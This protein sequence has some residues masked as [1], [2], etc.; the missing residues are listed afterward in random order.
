MAPVLPSLPS[1][2]TFEVVAR[3]MSFTRAAD[4][5]NIT[6]SAVSRQIRWLEDL[7]DTALFH[8]MGHRVNLTSDGKAYLREISGA[9]RRIEQS[10]LKLRS[11]QHGSTLTLA[12]PPAFGMRWLI[13]RLPKFHKANPDIMVSLITRADVFDF[14]EESVDAALHYGHEDWAGVET[15]PLLG[16]KIILVASPAYLEKDRSLRSKEGLGNAV[17]LQHLRRPNGWVEWL[18][19]AGI[20]GVNAWA[21]PS[22]EHYYMLIQA[23]AA[24]LGFALVPRIIVEEELASGQ[25][26]EPLGIAHKARETY[27]LVYPEDRRDHRAIAKLR[28]WLIEESALSEKS[29]GLD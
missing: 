15:V 1:L 4:E 25:L 18:S 6:Q 26:V 13:P 12:T 3:H 23:A 19:A 10:T 27:C 16:E 8:R 28:D 24:G 2:R 29:K 11:K 17:L 9:L 7:L 5:L 20:R 14:L 21:G 22:Y